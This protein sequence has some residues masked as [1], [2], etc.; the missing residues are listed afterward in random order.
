MK[1]YLDTG[2]FV[3]Y[4]VPRG[5]ADLNLRS[6]DRNGRGASRLA[7]D[8]ELLL[9]RI[10][11][12][13]AGVTSAL[14][15]YEAEEVLYKALVAKTRGVAHAG[16]MIVSSAR[17]VVQ[18]LLFTARRYG[19]EV[20]DLSTRTIDSQL[21][22][23]ELAISG[24]RAADALHVATAISAAADVLVTTDARIHALSGRIAYPSGTTLHCCDS[25]GALV[26][27]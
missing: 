19:I 11:R 14:T 18:Q 9:T 16:E 25:D 3:D 5:Y 13:H 27:V 4:L 23:P 15:F 24:I 26:L 2:F 6:S 12:K 10:S 8:A 20:L 17:A 22:E 7:E 21:R 1:I